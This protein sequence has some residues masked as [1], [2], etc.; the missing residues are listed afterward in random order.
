VPRVLTA[1]F[2]HETN[3]FSQ[4]KTDMALIRRRDFA[5]VTDLL[6][7]APEGDPANLPS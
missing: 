1:R 4:V 5:E 3:T 6:A 7:R 2:M